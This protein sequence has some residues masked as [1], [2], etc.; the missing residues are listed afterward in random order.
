VAT[1]TLDFDNLAEG[2][3]TFQVRAI[4]AVGRMSNV[5]SSY[6]TIDATPPTLTVASDQT[7]E[8]TGAN[9]AIVTYPDAVASDPSGVDSLFY[10]Q[11][12]NTRF[13]LGTTTVSVTADDGLGNSITKTFNVIVRDTTPPD[14]SF[15]RKPDA[16]T[17]SR[18]AHFEFRTTDV[19]TTASALALEFILDR[20]TPVPVGGL[21]RDFTGLSDGLHTLQ[22]RATDQ[23]GNVSTAASFNWT[24]DGT[25]PVLTVPP[26]QTVEATGPNGAT[27]TFAPPSA[28]DDAGPVRLVVSRDSGT[29]FPLGRTVVTVTAIDAAGNFTDRT[30][31]ILVQ[32][33]IPPTISF[34]ST[35]TARTRATD[36]HFRL[37]AS[38]VVTATADLVVQTSLDFQPWQPVSGLAQDFTALSAGS[39]LLQAR[40]TDEAQNVSSVVSFS[41]SIEPNPATIFVNPAY[42][43]P[44]GSVVDGH[45]IDVDAYGTIQQAVDVAAAGGTVNVA[46][47]TYTENVVVP[48]RLTLHAVGGTVTVKSLTSN[49]TASLGLAGQFSSTG[50]QTYN[51]PVVIAADSALT[52]SGT[53]IVFNSTLDGDGS[54]PWNL[55]IVTTTPAAQIQFNLAVGGIQPLK[56]L[57]INNAGPASASGAI[58]GAGTTLTKSGAG[59]LT[60]S[61]VNSYTGSTTINGGTVFVDGS[62]PVDS[63]FTINN[64]A[65][66]GGNGAIDGPLTGNSGSTDSPGHSPGILN[67][68]SLTLMTGAVFNAEIGGNTAGTGPGHYDQ[69][70]VI[71]TVHLG[72]ATL[73]LSLF[74][75]YVPRAGDTYV[76][77]SNDSSDAIPDTFAGL[78]E[79]ATIGPSFLGNGRTASIT[80]KGG[81]GND[82]AVIVAATVSP[83]TAG[84]TGPMSGVRGQPLSFTLTATDSLP[85]N[86]AAGFT[87]GIDWDGNGAVDQTV[88][89][90]SGTVVQHVY[91]ESGSYTVRVTAMDKD[92]AVSAPAT[93][94]VSVTAAAVLSDPANPGTTALFIGG[95]PGN[96]T[97]SITPFV[98]TAGAVQV[99][100]AGQL[101]VHYQPTGRVV[102]YGQGGTNTVSAAGIA[103][104]VWL[105]GGDGMDTF[106][107]SG[108]SGPN[109]LVGGA[110]N[111]TLGV[112]GAGCSLLIGGTGQD[113][114]AGGGN[115]IL[116]AG[117]T[118]YDADGAAL[119]EAALGAI[120]AEWNSA[121]DYATRTAN[122]AGSGT[123]SRLNGSYFLRVTNVRATTTVFD[124]AS[125]DTLTGSGGQNWC[126]ANISGSGVLDIVVHGPGERAD[127]L[128]FVW[129]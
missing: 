8:A 126:F 76:I 28:N 46:A 116:I 47:G 108:A 101:P 122:L 23:A 129:V 33:T 91:T 48:R 73:K 69:E 94:A 111:D 34:A 106:T 4:N 78:A 125:K 25:P 115:D 44:S 5:A 1:S 127:D 3:H 12:S 97:I 109:V 49:V 16:F 22:V 31:S 10:S 65:T 99:V 98:G 6:W 87:Y 54:G 85:A 113:T 124:D 14:V 50:D 61:A 100:F 77:I 88:N 39:H 62:T 67:T 24:I 32:D 72:G 123:G 43:G 17:S 40:A 71:G 83:P 35:P 79:G 81:D 64:S 18:D 118:A 37:S 119:D 36:G 68:G 13:P 63:V 60:L 30:F 90:L 53:G 9:G 92:G 58:Q 74:N 112:S 75:G 27:V 93:S 55:S 57:S 52:D 41:W 121:R 7:F 105:F 120:M 86:Q 45:T 84:I 29:V 114:L 89:G 117:V 11:A 19:V 104:P 80:Y 51:G 21:S 56:S 42:T 96:D 2:L 128:T 26:D 59:A 95:T 82:V 110:G 103:H 15:A 70:V 38:D 20:Q 107:V 102:V 66:V